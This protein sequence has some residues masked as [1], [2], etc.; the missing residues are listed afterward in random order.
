MNIRDAVEFTPALII[1][2]E[3][4][5]ITGNGGWGY[6][7]RTAIGQKQDGTVLFLVIDG[8]SAV[9]VGATIRDILDI[10]LEYNAYNATNLD[11]GSSSVLML[12]DEVLNHPSGSDSDGQ[13]FL[14]N[15]WLVIDPAKY[16]LP[17]DRPP[18]TTRQDR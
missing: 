1:N 16:Q 13:R 12:G 15:A 4:A 17:T 10:M 18:Y 14:P 9:S 5:Q 7:P 2:G 6:A 3:P 11:G 8:R